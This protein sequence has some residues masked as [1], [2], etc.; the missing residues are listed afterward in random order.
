MKYLPA[1]LTILLFTAQA[2]AQ[3]TVSLDQNSFKP[4]PKQRFVAIDIPISP[5]RKTVHIRRIENKTINLGQVIEPWESNVAYGY[6]PTPRFGYYSKNFV[7]SA[8]GGMIRGFDDGKSRKNKHLELGSE[9]GIWKGLLGA[10]GFVENEKTAGAITG[11]RFN[12]DFSRLSYGGK[13][14]TGAKLGNFSGNFLAI[15][16]GTGY[17]ETEG[18][19]VYKNSGYLELDVPL[20]V[21]KEQFYTRSFSAES[22]VK[23]SRLVSAEGRIDRNWYR[24][25]IY[26]PDPFKYGVNKF[27]DLAV[28]G[29]LEAIP[30]PGRDIVRIVARV[31]KNFQGTDRLLFRNDQPDLQIY[32]RIVFK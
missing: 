26:S 29:S 9:A 18:D 22:R 16:Y 12:S 5:F 4:A 28:R 3:T 20:P 21:Y 15:R 30:W 19:Q 8:S 10:E 32:L 6:L 17:I 11:L 2:H 7:F 24:R 14:W 1:L 31:T 13:A 23:I 25:V 27:E